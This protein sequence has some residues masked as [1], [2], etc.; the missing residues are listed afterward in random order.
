[1]MRVRSGW[2]SLSLAVILLASCACDRHVRVT[3]EMTWECRPAQRDAQYPEAE[4]VMFRYTENPD[5]FDLASGRGL[6]RQLQGS[7]KGTA[8]VTYEVWGT[9]SRGLHGYRIE[10]VNG[11]PLRDVGGPGLSGYHGDGRG[12]QHPLTSAL[13]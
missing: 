2:R 9:A 10:L 1:M 11:Q 4:P 12:G 5:Y 13:H 7:G 6:C 8:Q 3:K